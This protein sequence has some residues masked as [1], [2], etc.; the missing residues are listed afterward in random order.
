MLQLHQHSTAAVSCWW[1]TRV[2]VISWC[3]ISACLSTRLL[4][5]RP[6]HDTR[7][8][9]QYPH[10]AASPSHLSTS[11]QSDILTPR[12]QTANFDSTSDSKNEILLSNAKNTN[13]LLFVSKQRLQTTDVAR[14]NDVIYDE[15]NNV[16]ASSDDTS[17]NKFG[18]RRFPSAIIIG[19][20]KGGT[21]A[22]LEFLRI[23]PGM[24]ALRNI[25][26]NR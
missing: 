16:T 6:S 3:L 7:Q 22:L 14:S 21:R 8:Q 11:N 25:R 9:L 4:H 24:L 26:L 10:L 19:V 20:K 17:D 2:C 18:E 1:W 15:T 13:S 5:D 23:H 12:L